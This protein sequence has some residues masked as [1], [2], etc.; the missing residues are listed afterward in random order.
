MSAAETQ[1]VPIPLPTYDRT[2]LTAGM[3]H[4]GVGNFHRA[5]QAAVIDQLLDRGLARDFAICGVG[6]LPG[7]RRIRDILRD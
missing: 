3:M 1:S 2:G 4:I 5:H 6:V 7:D